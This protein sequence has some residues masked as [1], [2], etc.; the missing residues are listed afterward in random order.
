MTTDTTITLDALQTCRKFAGDLDGHVR[1]TCPLAR[2]SDDIWRR[3]DDLR[4]RLML[5]ESVPV[6]PKFVPALEA[7]LRR[8]VHDARVLQ[9]LRALVAADQAQATAIARGRQAD[10]G[11]R[12]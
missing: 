12:A 1:S 11:A 4:Q 3:I 5:A 2:V 6:S 7:D 10:P 8:H 9:A